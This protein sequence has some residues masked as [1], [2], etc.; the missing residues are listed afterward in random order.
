M[1]DI[2]PNVLLALLAIVA[3]YYGALEA[4]HGLIWMGHHV[5]DAIVHGLHWMKVIR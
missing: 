1:D 4:W 3:A 5:G 2:D